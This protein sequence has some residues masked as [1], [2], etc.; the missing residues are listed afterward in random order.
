MYYFKTF[1]H[2]KLDRNI[3][4]KTTDLNLNN[5]ENGNERIAF[6]PLL[7]Y[8]DFHLISLVVLDISMCFIDY[9]NK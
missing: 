7:L 2:L 8:E 6:S 3:L 9:V 4:F 5:N 1:G